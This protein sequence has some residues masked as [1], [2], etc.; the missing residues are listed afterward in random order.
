MTAETHIV[1]E[2]ISETQWKDAPL[3]PRIVRAIP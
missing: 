3:G 1:G 2:E